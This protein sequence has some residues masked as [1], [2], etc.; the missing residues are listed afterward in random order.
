MLRY[1]STIISDATV[2]IL[3]YWPAWI[4]LAA[5]LIWVKIAEWRIGRVRVSVEGDASLYESTRRRIILPIVLLLLDLVLVIVYV[6]L[7]THE[8]VAFSWYDLSNKFGVPEQVAEFFLFY[9]GAAWAGI[10][11]VVSLVLFFVTGRDKRR[12]SDHR[13]ALISFIAS[14]IVCLLLILVGFAVRVRIARL[15]V[16]FGENP[17][18]PLF[19]PLDVWHTLILGIG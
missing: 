5:L 14:A 1:V 16:S 3:S 2:G 7:V 10:W 17:V 13:A 15:M 9:G 12:Y 11:S 19:L 8:I 4:S 18:L 6:S